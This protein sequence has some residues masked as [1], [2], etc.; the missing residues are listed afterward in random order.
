MDYRQTALVG[1]EGHGGTVSNLNAQN[2][3]RLSGNGA[4]GL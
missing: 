3:A 4:I 2:T 1:N